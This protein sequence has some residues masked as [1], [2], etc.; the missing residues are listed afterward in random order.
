MLGKELRTSDKR[1][2][3]NATDWV[4]F[5]SFTILGWALFAFIMVYAHYRH[6]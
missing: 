3:R 2:V 6:H 1:I 4:A 5:W